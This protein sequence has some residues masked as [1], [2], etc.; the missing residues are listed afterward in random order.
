[1]APDLTTPMRAARTVQSGRAGTA[2]VDTRSGVAS[3]EN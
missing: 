1:M 3:L 2:V